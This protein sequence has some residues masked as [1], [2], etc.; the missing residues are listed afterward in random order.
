MAPNS[1]PEGSGD[2]VREKFLT[3]RVIRL[4]GAV[5]E[6]ESLVRI[7]V[8][9]RIF[10]LNLQHNNEGYLALLIISK[11]KFILSNENII[12]KIKYYPEGLKLR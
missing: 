2:L 5:V 6:L 10:L 8:Q 4:G 3:G 1:G 9:A 12:N 11:K 7:V